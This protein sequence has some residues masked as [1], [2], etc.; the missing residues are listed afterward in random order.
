MKKLA[1][2]GILPGLHQ[3]KVR[4]TYKLPD[5]PGLR[6]M[7]NT[8]RVSTHNVSHLSEIPEKG[9]ILLALT[10]F[11]DQLL[12]KEKGTHTQTVA[13]G[14][15]IYDYIGRDPRIPEN[16][17]RHAIVVSEVQMFMC[18]FI[19]RARMAGSLWKDFYSK[20]IE[21]PYGLKLP[22]GMQLM[23]K[24]P[25]PIFTPTDKSDTD[26][27]VLVKDLEGVT[28]GDIEA[29]EGV[30]LFMR[31]Y[32]LA[33]RIDIIDF[34]GEAG[35]LNGRR[36]LADE[37]GTPDCCR[38]VDADSIRKGE[39]PRWMDKEYVR[40]EAEAIWKKE[41]R[42]KFPIQFSPDVIQETRNRYHEIVERLTGKP[43]SALQKDL[44]IT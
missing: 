27:P 32:S 40:L 19:F 17:H 35:L 12:K 4:D 23:E 42:G 1:L 43:L 20:G 36:T 29:I 33:Q 41:G 5:F 26:D 8:L 38:F 6:L 28:R 24:F 13:W 7:D 10:L 37:Y 2:E 9:E 18:E 15:K 14:E 21:N 34:K 39:E 22:P 11:W 3:G 25:H 44:G 31:N 16:F 30:Y